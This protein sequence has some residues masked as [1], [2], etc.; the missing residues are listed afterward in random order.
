MTR[1]RCLV[2]DH[3]DTTVQSTPS[4]HYPSFSDTMRRLRP[5][6]PPVSCAEYTR[7]WFESIFLETC[8]EVYRFTPE[9]MKFQNENW[10]RFMEQRVPAFFEGMPEV[11]RRQRAEGGLVCVV[12]HSYARYIRRDYA[13][14]GLPEPDSVMGWEVGA[15][16]Q[17]PYPE[18]LE[19]LMQRYGLQRS[20]ILMVDDLKPGFDMARAAGCDFVA[21][22]WG[23][24]EES[25]RDM[26]RAGAQGGCMMTQ[27]SQLYKLLFDEEM[28]K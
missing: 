17:K 26:I 27:V 22:L 7:L 18:P 5:D 11:I 23:Y 19:V 14:A 8:R 1:Y 25:L 3:D 10:L 24:E 28:P 6:M 2:L 12:S 20:D 13:A 16:H 9:E 15:E 21:A 4:V